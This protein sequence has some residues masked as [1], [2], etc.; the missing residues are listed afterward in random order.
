MSDGMNN[1]PNNSRVFAGVF[2]IAI[3][4]LF[5]LKQAGFAIFPY[6]LFTWPMILIAVGIYSGVK[7]GFRGGGWLVMILIGTFFLLDDVMDMYSLRHYLVPAILVGVGIMLILRPKNSQGW[8]RCDRNKWKRQVDDQSSGPAVAAGTAS[9]FQSADY[10]TTDSGYADTTAERLDATAIFGAVKKN[11]LSKNFQGGDATSIFGGSEIDLSK[12]DINGT[13]LIDVTA[14][15]GGV[16]LI[17]PSHWTVRQEVAAIFGGVEDK[18]D[19]H[20]IITV[21]N[22]VLVLKGTAFMGGIEITSYR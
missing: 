1:Q 19:A 7:H 2:I 14:I 21:Q 3:G 17:V 13:V 5:F 6:W 11:I 20:S 22:K 9:S 12:A 15:L 4:V 18:R 10:I 16:K 8:G